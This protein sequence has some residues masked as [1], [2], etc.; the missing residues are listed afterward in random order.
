MARKR[1]IKIDDFD[2]ELSKILDEYSGNVIRQ[3]K[4]ATREVARVAMQE[5]KAGSN[6]LTGDYRRGWKVSTE[7][8]VL[9]TKAI[10]H[11]RTD[12]QLAH[13]LEKG[14]ALRGGG[15]APAFPHIAPAEQNAIKNMEK[16]IKKIAQE[17]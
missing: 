16:A 3:T 5:V 11:N 12:Y 14:H 1:K 15:R 10:V 13:L 17:S 8:D 7:T 2:S 4:T 6:V 9:S